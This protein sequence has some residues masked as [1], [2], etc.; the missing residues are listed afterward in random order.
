MQ[1]RIA[2]RAAFLFVGVHVGAVIGVALLGISWSG[3]ALA[4]AL[5]A[6]RMFALTAGVHRY[7]AHRT[8]KTSRAFQFV[9]AVIATASAQ[10]GVLWWVSHH[11][12]HHKHTEGDADPHSRAKGFWW[13]HAGWFLVHTYDE[14]QWNQIPDFAKYRELRWLDRHYFV[15]VLALVA[16]LLA[17]GGLPAFVWGFCVSTVVVW[18]AMFSLN[19]VGHSVG[20]RRY[21]TRDHSRNNVLVALATFGEGW[22]NNHHF[23]PGSARNGFYWWEIDLSYYMLR[24]LAMLGVVW[25]VRVVPE[26]VRERHACDMLDAAASRA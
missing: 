1:H 2:W 3:I 9:L 26:E 14:T 15:P 6:L 16:A 18:H 19:S 23:Y 24:A 10:L 17:F 13:A 11:R 25:D 12:L 20:Q 21:E 5:Y 7:F 8:F 4:V 22:H